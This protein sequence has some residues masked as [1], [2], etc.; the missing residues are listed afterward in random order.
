MKRQNGTKQLNNFYNKMKNKFCN[1]YGD[2]PHQRMFFHKNF[3]AKFV[4]GKSQLVLID[5]F[6]LI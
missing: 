4:N 3:K 6:G 2:T 5:Y 1:A